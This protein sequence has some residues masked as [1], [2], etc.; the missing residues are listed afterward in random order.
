MARL[1]DDNFDVRFAAIFV[2]EGRLSLPEEVVDAITAGVRDTSNSKDTASRGGGAQTQAYPLARLAF[3]NLPELSEDLLDSLTACLRSRWSEVKIKALVVLTGRQNLPNQSID[4]ITE[5][6]NDDDSNV[7]LAAILVFEDW[8]TLSDKLLGNIA[9]CL[10]RP[11]LSEAVAGILINHQA[12]FMI[13]E[14]YLGNFYDGL[15][16]ISNYEHTAWQDM[17]NDSCITFGNQENSEPWPNGFA[18]RIRE[19][20]EEYW[21]SSEEYSESSEE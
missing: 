6:F 16:D 21:E 9:A 8:T 12:L 19:S 2:F 18:K 3:A 13:P 7:Q 17:G 14:K 4:A 15:T 1:T 10:Q 5:R 11:K 20:S